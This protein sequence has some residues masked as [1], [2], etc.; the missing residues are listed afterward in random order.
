MGFHERKKLFKS[1]QWGKPPPLWT[2]AETIALLLD[3]EATPL[4]FRKAVKL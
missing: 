3:I 2:K 1:G 4:V